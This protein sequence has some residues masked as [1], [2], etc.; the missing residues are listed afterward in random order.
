MASLALKDLATPE[1]ITWCP[2][3]GNFG[4]LMALKNALL[5]LGLSREETVLVTGIGCHGKI[6]NYV[7]TAGLHGIHGR[8]LPAATG[9]ALANP[10]LTVICHAG[11][12]DCY[13]EGWE[14][15]TPT[16]RR[17]IDMTLIV[18]DNMVLGLTTGQATSTSQ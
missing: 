11:D 13:D 7:N 6:T 1:Q 2:G 8:T 5:E 4:I 18:H 9:I 16:L 17:N 14:H 15:F 12:S 3:C 10:D